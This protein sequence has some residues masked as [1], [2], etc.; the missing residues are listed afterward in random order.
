MSPVSAQDILT[1]YRQTFLRGLAT[2]LPT[3]LTL[4][5]VY[6]CWGFVNN[7]IAGPIANGIKD[8]LVQTKL[9]NEVDIWVP[10]LWD[11][12]KVPQGVRQVRGSSVN[13]VAGVAACLVTA[14]EGV[15]TSALILRK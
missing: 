1:T 2:V 5:I 14:G 6:A 11:F 13:P 3:L 8:Q 10:P 9:G 4:W 12:F 7:G 15:P